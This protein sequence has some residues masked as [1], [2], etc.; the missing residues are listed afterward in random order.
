MA[1]NP[2]NK[3]PHNDATYRLQACILQG[4][5]LLAESLCISRNRPRLGQVPV[6]VIIAEV[7]HPKMISAMSRPQFLPQSAG[8]D[9]TNKL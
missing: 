9:Q 6:H 1:S 3:D 7:L 5:G 8:E 4:D 2:R